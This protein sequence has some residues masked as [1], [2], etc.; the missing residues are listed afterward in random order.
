MAE[1]EA[2]IEA[3]K[4][5]KDGKRQDA[6]TLL[7]NA[8]IADPN[9][10]DLWFGLSYCLEDQ[11]QIQYCLKRVVQINPEHKK[12]ITAL[13]KL[14]H[15]DTFVDEI[16]TTSQKPNFNS[17]KASD[18]ATKKPEGKASAPSKQ[19]D[20][21]FLNVVIKGEAGGSTAKTG[22]KW[23]YWAFIICL[24][25]IILI[26]GM[27]LLVQYN[28]TLRLDP[29][30]TIIFVIICLSSFKWFPWI[31]NPLFDKWEKYKQGAKA[32]E[33]VGKILQ[34][35]GAGFVV[36]N[37]IQTGRGNIDHVVI[38]KTGQVIV[39]ETKSHRG[40]LEIDGDKLFINDH[41]T[42]K[43]FIQQTLGNTY[44]LREKI[45]GLV[46]MKFWVTPVIVFT[47]MYVPENPPIKGV[48]LVNSRYLKK[49]I[50]DT[51]S[52]FQKNDIWELRQTIINAV[53]K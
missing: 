27:G 4:L 31:M 42:E 45:I 28:K 16:K 10:E 38:S 12:A 18:S 11:G 20:D 46:K 5:Y 35:L 47:S 8:I 44:W 13:Q 40:Y 43:D 26:G 2:L 30:I 49:F 37:D 17:N 6:R 32:E 51:S 9:D 41:K 1:N 24:F 23:R 33:K 36:I 19:V 22:Q 53:G 48:Y 50:L 39:I 29:T 15:S 7:A 25:V 34:S 14:E 3:R 21:H 52:N